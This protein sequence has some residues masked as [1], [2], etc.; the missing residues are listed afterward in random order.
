[1]ARVLHAAVRN[2]F[3][4]DATFQGEE[5]AALKL[6]FGRGWVYANKIVSEGREIVGYFFASPLHRFFAE[7]KLCSQNPEG[8]I[9]ASLL[10]L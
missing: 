5:S 10:D 7:W 6:C 1:M 2:K 4:E 8:P 3:I 9:Q